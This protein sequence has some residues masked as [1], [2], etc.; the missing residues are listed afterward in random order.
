MQHEIAQQAELA[1]GQLDVLAVLAAALARLVQLQASGLQHR[2][3]GQTVGT[4][5]QRLDAQQLLG[6][7]GFGQVV[8]GAGLETIV[9]SAQEPRAVR[10][11]TGVVTPAARQACSTS[12]RLAGQSES[13]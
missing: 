4:A 9:R 13:K 1:S 8:V 3:V 12:S 2:L 11:S 6:M 10:I 7:E 5:Q